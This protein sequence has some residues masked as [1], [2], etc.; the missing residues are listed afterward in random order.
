MLHPLLVHCSHDAQA[1]GHVGAG[2]VVESDV[3]LILLLAEQAEEVVIVNLARAWLVAPGYVGGVD[4][5]DEVEVVT[6]AAG[7]VA[8]TDLLVVDA[9]EQA[10]MG[11]CSLPE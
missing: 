2:D 6:D 8:L 11:G 3:A 4:V 5:A 7:Q 9:V 10:D 1:R